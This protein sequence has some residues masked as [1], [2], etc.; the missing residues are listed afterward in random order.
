MAASAL[1]A[2][3][4]LDNTFNFAP[5][6]T[7][8]SPAF[9]YIAAQ[10]Y[11]WQG[12]LF[13]GDTRQINFVNDP[14]PPSPP[15]NTS[16][17]VLQV[18]Y[19]KGSY[20]QATA[21]SN[22]GASFYPT[23]PVMSNATRAL[24][25]Y[26]VAF[27]SQFDWVKGGKLPGLWA[28]GKNGSVCSGGSESDGAC[29]SARLMW[30]ANGTGEVNNLCVNGTSTRVAPGSPSISCNDDYGLSVGRGSFAFAKSKYTQVA[31]YVQLNS[32]PTALDGKLEFYANGIKVISLDN[33]N[34]LSSTGAT[35]RT[36][37]ST[38]FGGH[39]AT[40][41]STSDNAQSYYRNMQV[42]IAMN[43]S[44]ASAMV[45]PVA[46]DHNR[47]EANV[48]ISSSSAAQ[49]TNTKMCVTAVSLATL[50]CFLS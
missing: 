22:G 39:D 29:F 19:P 38:F 24:L 17:P 43:Q 18:N 8:T 44:S 9:L 13:G 45:I 47:A 42:W 46:S 33:I 35:L 21:D 28:G 23:P 14:F 32:Q 4:A 41:A 7:A 50:L 5:P 10:W 48:S 3:Y 6:P 27:S 25:T 1:A 16:A 36:F 2:A 30:R 49:V 34:F 11:A 26:E 37:F 12:K 15:S 31:L 20:R 40:W